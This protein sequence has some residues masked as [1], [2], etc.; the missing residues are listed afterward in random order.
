MLLS[1]GLACPRITSFGLRSSFWLLRGSAGERS[2][3]ITWRFTVKMDEAR[4]EARK[5]LTAELGHTPFPPMI[6]A[7]A[8]A[9][10][11]AYWRGATDPA[12]V[13]SLRSMEQV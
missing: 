12:S 2:G 3:G 8:R 11:S 5:I 9:I 7:V 4:E 13:R 6:E 1:P 10:F